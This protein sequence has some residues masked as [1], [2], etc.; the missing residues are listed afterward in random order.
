VRVCYFGTY[1][2]E[3]SRNRILIEG[4]RQN[5]VEV[6]ECQEPLWRGV[7]DRVAQASGGWMNPLFW[8]RAGG[9]YLRLIW[10]Y[11]RLEPHDVVIVGYPG[12]FDVYC[13]KLLCWLRNRTLVWDIFMSI[14]LIAMERGLARKSSFTVNALRAIERWAC[15]LPDQLW[16]DTAEYVA[17]FGCAHRVPVERF[18]LVPTGADER[19][20]RPVTAQEAD[21]QSRFRVIYHGS[22]IPNHGIDVIIGAAALLRHE[23]NLEVE[24]IGDGPERARAAQMARDL[25]LENVVF[26]DWL[27]Q[28]ELVRHLALADVCLGV[29][30]STPQSL[31]TIQN[32]IYE[33]LALAKPVITG[34]S[35]T[36][37]A[38]LRHG[39]HVYLVPRTDPLAL[40]DAIRF[41]RSDDARRAQL[42]REGNALFCQHYTVAAIGGRATAHLHELL[43][44]G[45]N[46]A[47]K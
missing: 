22:F 42:A 26:C 31:M 38:A 32:K 5:G 30:G 7:E 8:L 47:P 35:P 13:A 41:L 27:D 3:Y 43:S 16:L 1:R 18:R 20:F 2:A 44:P 46:E 24:L 37:R 45:A 15:Q 21:G 25:E 12:Q 10:R 23:L 34:D 33:G 6:I 19:V 40:A 4:L 17:W 9:V 29:F 11:L 36:I 28:D 14:Y 39:W